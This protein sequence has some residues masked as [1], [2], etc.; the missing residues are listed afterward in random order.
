[1][2]PKTFRLSATMSSNKLLPEKPVLDRIFEGKETVKETD[3]GFQIVGKLEGDT[4][5]LNG[6]P[7]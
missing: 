2:A 7:V 3:Q 6:K 4:A 1:M 5:A